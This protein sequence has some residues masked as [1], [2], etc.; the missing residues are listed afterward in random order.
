MASNEGPLRRLLNRI[1]SE[2]EQN[3]GHTR[4]QSAEGNTDGDA[5]QN[6]GG[7]AAPRRQPTAPATPFVARPAQPG[8]PPRGRRTPPTAPPPVT[9]VTPASP[10][11][12][13]APPDLGVRFSVRPA[14]PVQEDPP[15]PPPSPSYP[16]RP[17]VEWRFAGRFPVAQRA[18]GA[19][20]ALHRAGAGDW[21]C[22]AE[23]G[24]TAVW[25]LGTLNP[26]LAAELTTLHGGEPWGLLPHGALVAPHGTPAG[27][28][29]GRIADV[30]AWPRLE[31]VALVARLPLGVPERA[32]RPAVQVLTVRQLL[33]SVLRQAAA[34][35]VE[36]TVRAVRAR[37]LA[38]D[39]AAE[40]T[41]TLLLELSCPETVPHA[42]VVALAALPRTSVC[43]PVAGCERL[44]LDVRLHPPVD[45]EVLYSPVPEGELWLVGD[46][47]EWPPLRLEL[48]GE[49]S[50]APAELVGV[51]QEP[52]SGGPYRL[53]DAALAPATPVRI[54]PDPGT[55]GEVDAV[56]L[57][58]DELPL[59]RRYLPGR[60]LGEVAFLLPGPGRHLLL[61][62]VGL[63]RDL[64]FGVPLRRIGPGG[65]FLECGYGL[66]PP[67][68]PS[69]RA[70]L[71]AVDDS[72]AVVCWHGGRDRFAL[73]PMVPVWTLWA[74]TGPVEVSAGLS[75]AGRELLGAL[76]ELVGPA[77]TAGAADAALREEP[78]EALERAARL[79][80]LGDKEG[81][82]EAFRAAG[83][84]LEAARLFEEA[85][86]DL[87]EDP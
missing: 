74:P 67:L 19:V 69:A 49:A 28:G 43:R 3:S 62:P 7:N 78:G 15:V 86:L 53:P 11:H 48:V 77:R 41:E 85:A 64:P 65:C 29:P 42:L 79:R 25:L 26:A 87:P 31:A 13:A 71:F 72:S 66:A 35:G 2:N 45:E 55:P 16:A 73:A 9:P 70:R 14:H 60:P 75:A 50:P 36:A 81:A 38:G 17:D 63:A 39:G 59:L 51:A 44:L 57:L 32:E 30:T 40:P 84:L 24:G 76:E 52:P 54:V 8:S 10:E 1:A 83:D 61:E 80:A 4:E 46:R 20:G 18:L 22:H 21:A 68:P 56:L 47:M 6:A 82:A 37:P 34:F 58:D 33:A 12:R 5:E 23:P 27:G